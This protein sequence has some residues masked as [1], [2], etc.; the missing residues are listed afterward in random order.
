MRAPTNPEKFLLGIL[1]LVVLGGG[2][3]FGGSALLDRQRALEHERKILHADQLEAMA[4]LQTKFLW[5]QRLGWLRAHQPM[6]GDAND[7]QAQ[8]LNFLVKGARDHHLE[9]DEQNLGPIQHGPG[10]AKVA[11]EI[12]LK[13]S[14]EALCRWLADLQQPQN[15]YAVDFFSL[16]VDPDQKSVVCEV[17]I[18]RYFR[19]DG[20]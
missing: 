17:H 1:G 7:T 19:E 9:I 14:M 4:D 10:G 5:D 13:G 8:L 15:F 18:S 2:A 6:L 16:K 12:K 20:S 3:F 11:A